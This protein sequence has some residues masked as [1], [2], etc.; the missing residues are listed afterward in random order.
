MEQLDQNHPKIPSIHVK[1]K[2]KAEWAVVAP[3]TS[4]PAKPKLLVAKVSE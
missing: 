3:P 1:K 4:G 2:R